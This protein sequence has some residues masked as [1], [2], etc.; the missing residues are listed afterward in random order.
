MSEYV[1]GTFEL[2]PVHPTLAIDEVQPHT[3]TQAWSAAPDRTDRK[4]SGLVPVASLV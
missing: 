1:V 3:K 2:S 4:G